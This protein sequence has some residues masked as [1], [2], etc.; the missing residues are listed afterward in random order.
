MYGAAH[1]AS[2][3]IRRQARVFTTAAGTDIVSGILAQQQAAGGAG[4]I[5]LNAL[6][7]H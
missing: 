6:V 5:D 3:V 7:I 2:Q 4:G 1:C